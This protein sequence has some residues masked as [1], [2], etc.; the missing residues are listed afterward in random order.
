MRSC[1]KISCITVGSTVVQNAINLFSTE[2]RSSFYSGNLLFLV[3]FPLYLVSVGLR[4]EAISFTASASP[5]P[6]PVRASNPWLD[7]GL[8]CGLFLELYSCSANRRHLFNGAPVESILD[9]FVKRDVEAHLKLE[10]RAFVTHPKV[11]CH[12]VIYDRDALRG[13]ILA[14]GLGTRLHSWGYC[15]ACS[16]ELQQFREILSS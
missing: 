10:S 1:S 13:T 7:W 16:M 6:S 3:G 8:G 14:V 12:E 9:A 2:L 15:R 4:S 5:S 11:Y